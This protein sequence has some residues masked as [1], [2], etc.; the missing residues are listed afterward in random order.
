MPLTTQRRLRYLCRRQ[1]DGYACG[2]ED[3]GLAGL[4]DSDGLDAKF[5]RAV[6]IFD[7]HASVLNDKPKRVAF[8]GKRNALVGIERVSGN[9]SAGENFDI[10]RPAAVCA[11]CKC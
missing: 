6:G 10:L 7:P 2:H 8:A 1:L 11:E 3:N 9:L 4:C 5:V